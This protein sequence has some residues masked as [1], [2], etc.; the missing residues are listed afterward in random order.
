MVLRAASRGRSAGPIAVSGRAET[1][2]GGAE[3]LLLSVI[4]PVSIARFAIFDH[5]AQL[6]G[7][8]GK[9][10]GLV[11]IGWGFWRVRGFQ[12]SGYIGSARQIE[13]A[14]HTGEFVCGCLCGLAARIVERLRNVRLRRRLPESQHARGF[15]A[16]ISPRAGPSLLEGPRPGESRIEPKSSSEPAVTSSRARAK[17]ASRA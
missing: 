16:E 3:S 9:A 15:P 6:R 2:V 14:Q 17:S 10:G 12:F 13:R 5:G 7:E 4:V 11:G 8:R 1:R